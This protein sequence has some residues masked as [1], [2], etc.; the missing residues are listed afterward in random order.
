MTTACDFYLHE[1]P[2]LQCWRASKLAL[3]LKK[4]CHGTSAEAGGAETK[5]VGVVVNL[6]RAG[7][8]FCASRAELGLYPTVGPC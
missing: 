5:R 6:P 3:L 2:K 4:A 8:I 1:P 7:V